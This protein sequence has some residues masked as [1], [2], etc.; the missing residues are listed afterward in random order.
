LNHHK[1]IHHICPLLKVTF[2]P[3]LQLSSPLLNIIDSYQLNHYVRRP[4]LACL[5][6]FFN[7][8]GVS[9]SSRLDYS[10]RSLDCLSIISPI[11]FWIRHSLINTF[12]FLCII[13]YFWFFSES[14][15]A[16]YII[17]FWI[18]F[19]LLFY[20]Y[21]FFDNYFSLPF[22]DYFSFYL[23]AFHLFLIYFSLNISSL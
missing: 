5:P 13:N 12:L 10:R 21:Q 23:L 22:Q 2:V 7:K 19:F 4:L 6:T 11:S 3:A 15:S 1:K 17:F 8:V 14:S 20:Q 16:I 18:L 9:C